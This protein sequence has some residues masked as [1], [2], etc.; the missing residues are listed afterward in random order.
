VGCDAGVRAGGLDGARAR[1]EWA[2]GSHT[3]GNVL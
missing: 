3:G 2:R 1:Q